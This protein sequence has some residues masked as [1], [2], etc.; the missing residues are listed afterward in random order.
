MTPRG[1]VSIPAAAADLGALARW[2]ALRSMAV[3]RAPSTLLGGPAEGVVERAACMARLALRLERASHRRTRTAV[4][5]PRSDAVLIQ[6][7]VEAAVIRRERLPAAVVRIAAAI[8]GATRGRGRP[9]RS[10]EQ[11]EA[12]IA[13]VESGLFTVVDDRDN[14]RDKAKARWLRYV[15]AELRSGATLLTLRP[16]PAR[17]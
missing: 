7:E 4:K 11:I 9:R 12:R 1:Q 14:R 16:M 10:L 17:E 6:R 15:Q 3:A 2:L 5:L 8:G 13:A